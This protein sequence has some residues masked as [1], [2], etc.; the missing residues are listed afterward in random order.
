MNKLLIGIV[1]LSLCGC[2][3]SGPSNRE[4]EDGCKRSFSQQA[5]VP[6]SQLAVKASSL[7]SGRW[8]L[9]MTVTRYDGAKRSLNATAVMD[10]NGDIHYYTD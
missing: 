9:K 2:G 4:I 5:G 1:L 8:A 7:G 10:K 3:P 6:A